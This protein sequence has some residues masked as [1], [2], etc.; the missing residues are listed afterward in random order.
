MKLFFLFLVLSI[1]QTQNITIENAWMRNAS[2]GMNT[3]LFF[4]IKNNGTEPDTL[5]KAESDLA[6]LVQI[7]ETYRNGDMM[8]MREVKNIVIEPDSTFQFKPGGY[9]IMLI[10]VKQDLKEGDTEEVSVFFKKAGE[11]KVSA[12]VKKYSK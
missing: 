6:E 9:H 7:H 11:I 2:E 4:D 10:M 1:P 8:G 12:A 5:Y 3:G